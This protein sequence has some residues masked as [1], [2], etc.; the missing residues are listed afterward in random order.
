MNPDRYYDQRLRNL[1]QSTLLLGAMALLCGWLARLVGGDGF[2]W[3]A[4]GLLAAG[5]LFNPQLSP[6]L[7]LRLYGARPIDPRAAPQLYA[8]LRLLAERA[9]LPH[10]PT[11]FYL[12]SN[13]MNAFAT[14]SRA[15][16]AIAL[17]D[18]LLRRMELRELA[19]VL[20]H[21]V[22]HIRHQD[23][24]VMGF[25]D[26][27]SRLTQLLSMVG[28]LLLLVSLPLL[29][30]GG[31]PIPWLPILLLLAAPTPSALAQLA[32]SRSREYDADLGAALLTGDP[33]GLAS[34]LQKMEIYQGR[35][36]E[37]ILFPG[38]RLP[39][40]SLLRTHPPTSERIRRLLELRDQPDW[41]LNSLPPLGMLEV[42]EIPGW[43]DILAP[44]PLCPRWRRS[45]LWY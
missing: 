24:R 18:G 37:Q 34:A 19:G 10:L 5:Y 1:L 35:V 28:Q 29:L 2:M 43:A 39:D 17:S 13:V 20:G 31:Y 22:S 27:V 32:L 7:L 42:F 6:W 38:Q 33:E 3:L 23:L 11:L 21:E 14:G 12:P 40:P 41:E 16:A 25:A 8:V 15:R 36:V 44:Q 30:F 9:G 4:L 45:G 26:L